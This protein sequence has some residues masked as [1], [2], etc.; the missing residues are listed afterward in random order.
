MGAEIKIQIRSLEAGLIKR[1]S[2]EH[3]LLEQ[4]T[5]YVANVCKDVLEEH[6]QSSCFTSAETGMPVH[7][8]K[9][10]VQQVENHIGHISVS[11]PKAMYDIMFGQVADA[12][13]DH[14][15]FAPIIMETPL[16]DD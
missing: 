10:F 15:V 9:P 2:P 13:I 14:I 7:M 6:Y 5:A 1:G 11:S 12:E 4:A 8:P 16:D 3:A